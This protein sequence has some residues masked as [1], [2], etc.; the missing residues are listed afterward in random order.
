VGGYDFEGWHPEFR[1]VIPET[2][3]EAMS[4]TPFA[5]EY[6]KLAANPKGFP[7]LARKVIALQKEPM[8]WESDVK[9][10]KVSVLIIA[11]GHSR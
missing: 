1:A 9:A 2:T 3:V 7:E 10:L 5:K 8:A 6:P 11:G 4:Q